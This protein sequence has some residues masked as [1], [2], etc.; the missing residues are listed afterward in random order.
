LRRSSQ[1]S[2]ALVVAAIVA[3]VALASTRA[4]AADRV[5]VLRFYPSGGGATNAQ[6]DAARAATREAVGLLHD[7]PPSDAELAAAEASV[8]DGTPDTSAEYRIA[9]QI[10][11]TQW[12]VA[13]H[14]DAHGWTYRLELEACQVATGRVE[15]LVR[16]ID[17]RQAAP[18]IAE[19]LTLLLRQPGVGDAIPPWDQ[20]PA[21]PPA[22]AVVTT[23]RPALITTPP[24][25]ASPPV[26][27]PENEEYG[28]A[29]PFA[30]GVGGEAVDAFQRSS[31]ARGASTAGFFTLTALY[32]V[33]RVP[34]LELVTDVAAG[35]SVPSS[36]RVDTGARYLG[37]LS[38]SAHLY[39]G[40]EGA[41]GVFI[42]LGGDEDVR[43]LLRGA[44]P[45]I[46]AFSNSAQIE[47]YPTVAYAMGGTAP[48][49]LAGGGARL[50]IRF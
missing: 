34:G 3:A 28:M 40:L 2:R 22:A 9:G 5:A 48:I 26:R 33:Q 41:F 20:G 23:T 24:P 39:A 14:I 13:G 21:P 7:V 6:L 44:L 46:W 42:D 30:V 18:Q 36:L 49:G 17:A 15:S 1:R 43:Y 45:V 4:L 16:E 11:G 8:Q 19:M 12:T 32:A 25:A 31:L 37:V 35:S 38:R 10:A 27:E 29:H 47:V 50:V